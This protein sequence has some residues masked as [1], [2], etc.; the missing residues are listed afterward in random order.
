MPRVGAQEEHTT[1][2]NQ[3]E[4]W[5]RMLSEEEAAEVEQKRAELAGQF[6]VIAGSTLVRQGRWIVRA[7]T[8]KE[9]LDLARK[10]LKDT[11]QKDAYLC[12]TKVKESTTVA[13]TPEIND[14]R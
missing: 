14:H 4:R 5:Q 7:N 12:A 9:A 6:V 8:A 1:T 13:I 2:T 10:A 11:P 3:V